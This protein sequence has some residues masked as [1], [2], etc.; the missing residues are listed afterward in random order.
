LSQG[1]AVTAIR[2]GTLQVKLSMPALPNEQSPH[3]QD[4]IYVIVRGYGVLVHDGERQPFEPGDLLFVA[5]GVPHHFA[6]FGD[7]LTVWVMFYG[8]EGGEPA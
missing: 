3:T 5:A 8:A 4:E 7:D 6:E 2:H 1:H